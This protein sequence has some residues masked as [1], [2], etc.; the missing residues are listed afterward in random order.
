MLAND[1]TINGNAIN[2]VG[3]I[4]YPSRTEVWTFVINERG[5]DTTMPKSPSLA[6]GQLEIVENAT[7]SDGWI[8]SPLQTKVQA[9]NANASGLDSVVLKS[10]LL[11]NGLLEN[12]N[13]TFWYR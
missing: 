1:A 13:A 12:S 9:F 10:H 5:L 11:G 6:N 7:N 8:S 3:H 2:V 4:Y